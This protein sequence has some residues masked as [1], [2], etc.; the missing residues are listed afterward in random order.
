[1][2]IIEY[3]KLIRDGIPEI[4]KK[5]GKDFK[6]EKMDK[7]EHLKYLNIK[8]KEELEEY[9]ED[10]EVEELC[11]LVE[12]I[13]GILRLKGISVEEFHSIRERKADERGS[14]V[15]GLKLLEVTEE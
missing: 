4:I 11:D 8:L 9:Y 14:F 15:E 7:E 5:S 1:M 2:K 12:V 13:Y 10:F 3:N 6:I